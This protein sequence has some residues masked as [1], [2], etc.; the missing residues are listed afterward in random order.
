MTGCADGNIIKGITAK[1]GTVVAA[2][3][4][5]VIRITARLV[6]KNIIDT[7]LNIPQRTTTITY[8]KPVISPSISAV[9][10]GNIILGI[11]PIIIVDAHQYLAGAV[12]ISI[13][14]GILLGLAVCISH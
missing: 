14:L 8:I 13:L 12:D 4:E 3:R 1:A 2:N 9:K 5:A 7:G 11:I 10:L 6:N